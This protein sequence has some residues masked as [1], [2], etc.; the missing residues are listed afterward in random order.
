M[1]TEEWT[2]L[3]KDIKK[4][5]AE[6]DAMEGVQTQLYKNL[7]KLDIKDAK[8]AQAAIKK[9]KKEIETERRTLAQYMKKLK[10]LMK[11]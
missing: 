4:W 3:D 8:H 9:L 10:K 11:D 7:N 6:K 5:I 1:N 2:Q